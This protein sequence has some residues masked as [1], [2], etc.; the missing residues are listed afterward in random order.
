MVRDVANA[1]E[2]LSK[3]D[4]ARVYA[5][6]G[7]AAD[8]FQVYH[9]NTSVLPRPPAELLADDPSRHQRSDVPDRAAGPGRADR[10]VQR[11]ADVDL[12][13]ASPRP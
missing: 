5:Y 8:N 12:A 11:V 13:P 9:P 1:P 6:N 10:D 3:L 2:C 4:E 7:I